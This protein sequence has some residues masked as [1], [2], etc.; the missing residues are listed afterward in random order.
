MKKAERARRLLA[1]YNRSQYIPESV[2]TIDSSADIGDSNDSGRWLGRTAAACLSQWEKVAS[3]CSDFHQIMTR[4]KA[5]PWTGSPEE[6]D[7][8]REGQN[9]APVANDLNDAMEKLD[10]LMATQL[11]KVAASLR[12]INAVKR[13]AMA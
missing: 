1:E 9:D 4:V 2:I 6:E 5:K 8:V 11:M 3:Q 12:A 13:S 7:F 10:M